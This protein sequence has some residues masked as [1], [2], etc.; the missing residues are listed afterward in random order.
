[1]SLERIKQL[2]ESIENKTIDN[3]LKVFKWSDNPFLAYQYAREIAKIKGMTIQ[4]IDSFQEVIDN[5]NSAFSFND[6]SYFY[7]YSCSTFECPQEVNLED[8]Q[9]VVVICEKTPIE[10]E[11]IY[12]FPK[13]EKWQVMAYIK[14]KCIGL[15]DRE[16]EWLYDITSNVKDNIYRLNNEADKIGC[17]SKEF[18]QDVFRELNENSGYSDI[19][20]LTI[21]N[22]TN[23]II[24]RDYNGI[25]KVLEEIDSIDVEGVGLITILHK[26]FKQVIDIQMGKNVTYE[27][28]G[29]SLK[30]FKAVEYNCGKFSSS[31]LIRIFN[32]ITD[33]D[34]KLKSGLLDLSNSRLIDYI[35]C[36]VMS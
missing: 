30:Q 28:L 19:S 21:F 26:N 6:E 31:E 3:S 11:T 13:L 15:G 20:P 22:F 32:F 8:I 23:A 18:H 10:S 24:K 17:F 12:E 7:I 36:G 25:K 33:I 27:S 14:S 34:Y 2:K 29:M 9:N 5:L 35:V 1:M 4:Y 16:I